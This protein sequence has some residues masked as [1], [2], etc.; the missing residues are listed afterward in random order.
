MKISEI[1]SEMGKDGAYSTDK[2]RNRRWG[3]YY[4]PTYDYIFR[5]YSGKI[6][7]V[8]IG[9]ETGASLEAWKRFFPE[10]NITGIDIVDKSLKRVPD[11]EYV[12]S[13]VKLFTPTHPYDIVIDDGS[14]KLSDVLYVVDNFKL[15]VGGVMVIEDCQAPQQWFDAIVEKTKYGVERIDF[16]DVNRQR[17]DFLILLRNYGYY[18]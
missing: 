6:D 13:D 8:E 7:I 2:N 14:H 18:L 9:T 10:A 4:G 15:K 11:V 17:D 3:H 12:I 16:R 1:L 5:P